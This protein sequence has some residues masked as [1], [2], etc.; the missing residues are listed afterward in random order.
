MADRP[1]RFNG[2]NRYIF[3]EAFWTS[4]VLQACYWTISFQI[5]EAWKNAEGNATIFSVTVAKTHWK[6]NWI[7][8]GNPMTAPILCIDHHSDL[9]KTKHSSCKLSC[10]SLKGYNSSCVAPLCSS[11][12]DII[13]SVSKISELLQYVGLKML[14]ETLSSKWWLINRGNIISGQTVAITKLFNKAVHCFSSYWWEWHDKQPS[15]VSSIT[16][17]TESV[18]RSTSLDTSSNTSDYSW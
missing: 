17:P 2:T 4:C 13:F 16:D 15:C 8:S 11:M 6:E 9:L 12:E 5:Q 1:M 10:N 14:P 18:A 3:Q 7:T